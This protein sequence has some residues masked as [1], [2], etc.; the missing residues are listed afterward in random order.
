MQYCGSRQVCEQL[1]FS[2]YS[3][4]FDG[5]KES[6]DIEGTVATPLISFS[7]RANFATS[8]DFV[9]F[10]PHFLSM[11]VTLNYKK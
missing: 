5:I 2:P 6:S 7:T 3:V 8:C 1:H 10:I 4:A 9:S 11:L